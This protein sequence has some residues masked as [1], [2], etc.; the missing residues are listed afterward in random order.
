V[1]PDF[2]YIVE[3][4]TPTFL[5]LIQNGLGVPEEPSYGSWG[6]RYLPVNL[7]DRGIPK[8]HHADS[9][10]EVVGADGKKNA[11]SRATI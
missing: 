6:G 2:M 4:D 1:Y 7:S 5:Y 11:S 9:A 3:G 10:D 8:G